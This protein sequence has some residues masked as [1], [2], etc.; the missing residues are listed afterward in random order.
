MTT[1]DIPSIDNVKAPT[2]GGNFWHLA[3]GTICKGPEDNRS[4]IPALCGKLTRFGVQEGEGKDGKKFRFLELELLT[5]DGP[6]FLSASLLNPRD[7]GDKISVSGVTMARVAV[8]MAENPDQVYYITASQQS[9]VEPGNKPATY[10][11]VAI[12]KD[13]EAKP[14]RFP[15]PDKSEQLKPWDQWLVYEKTLKASPLYSVREKTA[16]ENSHLANLSKLLDSKGKQTPSENPEFWLEKVEKRYSTK[17]P[18]VAAVPDAHWEFYFS[19]IGSGA[20]PD[21]K[22]LDKTPASDDF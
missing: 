3:E 15:I 10:C 7:G 19:A 4:T 13:G 11:N 2:G 16:S 6:Q 5:S 1:Q 21:S 22:L 17:Y 20:I 8:F 9:K 18:S 12:V 14:H